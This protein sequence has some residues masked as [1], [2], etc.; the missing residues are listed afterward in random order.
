MNLYEPIRTAQFLKH[1]KKIKKTSNL[2]VRLKRKI[3]KILANPHHYK[4]LRN[5][6]K[7]RCRT[8]IDSFVL[9]FE[10]NETEKT[11]TF[12]SFEHH[13]DSYK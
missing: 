5:V 12:H 2:G 10:V 11:I 7:N 9:I 4:P 8:H 6:L 13:D 3:E 1:T